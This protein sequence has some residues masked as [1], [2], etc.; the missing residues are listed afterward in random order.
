M[1]FK[2]TPASPHGHS[3]VMNEDADDAFELTLYDE[4]VAFTESPASARD[5]SSDDFGIAEADIEPK[6]L[7]GPTADPD[8][9]SQIIQPP[10]EDSTFEALEDLA[11]SVANHV[12]SPPIERLDDSAFQAVPV[13]QLRNTSDLNRELAEMLKAT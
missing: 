12:T 7:P 5:F 6:A 2:K 1:N 10:V 3:G 13:P 11:S 4:L 8:S 9:L